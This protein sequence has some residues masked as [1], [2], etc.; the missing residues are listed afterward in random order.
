MPMNYITVPKT[1]AHPQEIPAFVRW[2]EEKFDTRL[3]AMSH[4]ISRACVEEG[5]R[6]IRL[7]GPTCAGK[8]TTAHKLIHELEEAGC[9]VHPISLDDF[10]YGRDDLRAFA[11]T[12]DGRLDFDSVKALDLDTLGKS[13]HDLLTYGKA[14][15][16]VYDFVIGDRVEWRTLDVRHEAHPVFLLE[17]IQAVYPEVIAHLNGIPDRSIFSSVAEGLQIGETT[18]DPNEIRLMRR[19]VRDEA[20]RN[21]TPTFTLYLWHSVRENEEASILPH[22]HACDF[23]VNSLMGFDVHM[24]APHLKRIFAAHPVEEGSADY[25]TAQEL[26][27]KLEGIEEIPATLMADNSLYHEF[28]KL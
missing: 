19:L 23:H 13:F 17:G 26:L 14:E 28:I 24:L 15:I 10:F 9:V 7:S 4:A 3:D 6:V 20:K 8:T 12:A 21:A 2:W 18:F 25:A 11:K 1:F 27:A 22:A 16:P 5:V